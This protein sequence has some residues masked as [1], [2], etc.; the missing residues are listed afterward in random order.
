MGCITHPDYLKT[1]PFDYARGENLYCVG[2]KK[3]NAMFIGFGPFFADGPKTIEQIQQY[4][5]EAY[6]SPEKD[7]EYQEALQKIKEQSFSHGKILCRNI[8]KALRL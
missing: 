6:V 1:H 5:A 8:K 7:Q 3:R 4:L 2:F